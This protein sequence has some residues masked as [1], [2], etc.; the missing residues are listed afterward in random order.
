LCDPSFPTGREVVDHG[1]LVL[2]LRP[3]RLGDPAGGIA[4]AALRTRCRKATLTPSE[5]LSE[6]D[7]VAAYFSPWERVSLLLSLAQAKR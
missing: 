3:H 5:Q 7:L 2:P 4:R 6:A 1:V